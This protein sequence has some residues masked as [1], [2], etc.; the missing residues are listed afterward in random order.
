MPEH[1]TGETPASA[2]ATPAAIAYEE[3]REDN[4]HR[5]GRPSSFELTGMFTTNLR[6]RFCSTP[7]WKP[8]VRLTPVSTPC[9][10]SRGG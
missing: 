6:W 5:F 9:G 2:A 8:S 10:C 3:L 7:N 4:G 1:D